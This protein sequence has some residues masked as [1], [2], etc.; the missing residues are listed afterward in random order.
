MTVAKYS[1]VELQHLQ[2]TTV[3]RHSFTGKR[4]P[5]YHKEDLYLKKGNGAQCIYIYV[6][7]FAV[8]GGFSLLIFLGLIHG[9]I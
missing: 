4:F 8:K 6:Q 3:L 7:T 9:M 1:A 5:G 2:Y